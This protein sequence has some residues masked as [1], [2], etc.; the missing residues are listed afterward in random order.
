MPL[1]KQRTRTDC[2][3]ACLA[4]LC[5][6]SYEEAHRAIPWRP[7]TTIWGT[8]T[9]QLREAAI[10]L[11]YAFIGTEKFRLIPLGKR[12]WTEIPHNSL[13]KVPNPAEPGQ[14]HWVVWRKGKIYDPAWGVFRP[15]NYDRRPTSYATFV[16][17]EVQPHA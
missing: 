4:M 12:S 1:V 14:W 7:S 2:G 10:K 9:K 16:S 11:G 8:C 6:V 3:V 15:Q 17:M 5:K 13:V